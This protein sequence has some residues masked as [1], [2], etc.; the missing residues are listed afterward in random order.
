MKRGSIAV[1]KHLRPGGESV[2][3]KSLTFFRRTC[4]HEKRDCTSEGRQFHTG[5]SSY[6]KAR[7]RQRESWTAYVA[8][9]RRPDKR[10]LGVK[11][12]SSAF[13]IA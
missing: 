5:A 7:A 11:H 3:R 4:W 6:Q 1:K 13:S 12:L 10:Q 9:T 8:V 2:L